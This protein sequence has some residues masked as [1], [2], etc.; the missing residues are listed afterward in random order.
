MLNKLALEKNKLLVI[1]KLCV[2]LLFIGT[3]FFAVSLL[4]ESLIPGIVTSRVGFSK[5]SFLVVL[6]LLLSSVLAGRLGI[7]LAEEK[8]NKGYSWTYSDLLK[9]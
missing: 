3:I 6:P 4:A 1:Y 5:I 8:I 9:R 2:D 7:S